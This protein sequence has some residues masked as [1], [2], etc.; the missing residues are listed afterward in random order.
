[1]TNSVSNLELPHSVSLLE[2]VAAESI[3]NGPFTYVHSGS[4]NEITLKANID[5]F[6]SWQIVPKYLNDV[7]IR[8]TSSKILGTTFPNSFALAP[9]GVQSIFHP[10]GELASARAAAHHGVPF[11]AST[12]TSHSLEEIATHLGDTPRWFQLYWSKDEELAI[13]MVKRA[14]KAGYSAIVITVDTSLI[15]NRERDLN[16]GYS[17]LKLGKGSANY[18]NDPVFLERFKTRPSSDDKGVIDKIGDLLFNPSLTWEDLRTIKKHTSL[19]ILLKGILHEEDASKALDYGVDGL[20][21][22]NHGGRQLDGCIS[23]LEAL[24]PIADV[25]QD[26]IPILLDS[27]IRRGSDVIKARALG[28]SAVLLGRPFVYGLAV[29]GEQG[30]R[31]V[32]KNLINDIDTSLALTGCTSM[33]QVN[34]SIIRR[35]N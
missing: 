2:K 33:T 30:V 9:V 14:E 13:S 8:D 34:E 4:G 12:F 15:G 3:E 20:I 11:I 22:S 31:H 10:E 17:P 23:S 27:G 6:E 24:P 26:R 16:N 28:A 18:I 19:P 21:V 7:S 29:S 1:M 35:K 5:A 25:I 32:L